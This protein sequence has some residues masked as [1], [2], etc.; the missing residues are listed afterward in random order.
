MFTLFFMTLTI[1]CLEQKKYVPALTVFIV[2]GSSVEF[3]WPAL[4][5][6]ISV[7]QYKK[8][9]HMGLLIIAIL[10]IAALKF[11][12]GNYWALASI[13][14]LMIVSYLPTYPA[15]TKIKMA[16][17]LFLPRSLNNHLGHN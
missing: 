15:N 8:T 4:T 7:W 2:G 11:I 14:I 10:S 16:V 6:G 17:L 13:P 1:F 12:N 3:W 5:L 9:A